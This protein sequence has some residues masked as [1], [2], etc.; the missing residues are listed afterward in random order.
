M[1][2]FITKPSGIFA[3][4]MLKAIVREQ[5]KPAAQIVIEMTVTGVADPVEDTL[6]ILDL[7]KIVQLAKSSKSES[8][9]DAVR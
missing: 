9:R 6:D 4:G 3:E 1:R 2:V 5:D 8:I 7:A